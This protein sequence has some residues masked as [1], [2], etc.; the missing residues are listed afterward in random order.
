[1]P[2][3]VRLPKIICLLS[4]TAICFL[5][6]G[7][8]PF[9]HKDNDER[10]ANPGDS[11]MHTNSDLGQVDTNQP[12]GYEVPRAELQ[13]YSAYEGP[14]VDNAS[15]DYPWWVHLATSKISRSLH[16]PHGL[17]KNLTCQIFLQVNRDGELVALRMIDPSG[18][19]AF[20]KACLEAI[21]WA[22]P[23]PS[24]PEDYQND[25]IGL[26]VPFRSK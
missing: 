12:I 25:R 2:G 5:L 26:T 21:R 23:F 3:S 22:E 19:T 4:G 10:A 18:S 7:C 9:T 6:S 17:T 16:L 15:F 11:L 20:D 8:W 13:P 14:K 24:L 1:M